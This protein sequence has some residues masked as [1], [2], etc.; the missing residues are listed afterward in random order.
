MA[1]L[2]MDIPRF[3]N[4]SLS[5]V[6]CFHETSLQDAVEPYGSSNPSEL[7]NT[8]RLIGKP[9]RYGNPI[10][11]EDCL[12][13]GASSIRLFDKKSP[14]DFIVLTLKTVQPLGPIMV[15]VESE[16]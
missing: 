7:K 1:L 4:G 8:I 13:T 15:N 10:F 14:A 2:S 12:R 9:H 3:Q 16:G 6:F 11:I 5:S